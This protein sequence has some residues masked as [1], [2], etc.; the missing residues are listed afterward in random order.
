[1]DG[2]WA[3]LYKLKVIDWLPGLGAMRNGYRQLMIHNSLFW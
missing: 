3:I 2:H 1:M